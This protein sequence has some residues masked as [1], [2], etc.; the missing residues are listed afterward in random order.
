M[1]AGT[2]LVSVTQKRAGA[3][4]PTAR[5][6]IS[7]VLNTVRNFIVPPTSTVVPSDPLVVVVAPIS[8]PVDLII[9]IYMDR[10]SATGW[11]DLSPWP[12]Y[13]DTVA[14]VTV[15]TTQT[16]WRMHADE[17][18]VA[19][20]TP[21]MMAWN[22]AT[23][24]W[25]RLLVT[26]VTAAGGELYDVVLST[27]PSFTI[28]VGSRISP[29]SQINET[30]A[31]AIEAYF[32][33][34]GPGEVVDTDAADPVAGRAYRRPKFNER[35]PQRAGS[36]IAGYITEALGIASDHAEVTTISQTKPDLPLSP[37]IG[38]ELLTV[39]RVMVYAVND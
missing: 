18:F 32:D 30:I 34:L 38:P 3:S 37:E 14:S 13:V 11:E 23:S 36:G 16:S 31:E 5:I 8:A 2:V 22:P 21:K 27:A 10:L 35:W 24:R 33:H 28:A 4:G 25:E 6:P 17:A 20:T 12:T 29:Y 15:V 26:S 19:G 7:T 39:Q 1:A 9:G